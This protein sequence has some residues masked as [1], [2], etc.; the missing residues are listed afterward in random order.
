MGSLQLC[1][2]TATMRAVLILGLMLSA[3]LTADE[4]NQC[5]ER[6]QKSNL[7]VRSGHWTVWAHLNPSFQAWVSISEGRL[8]SYRFSEPFGNVSKENPQSFLY[9]NAVESCREFC[10]DFESEIKKQIGFQLVA[11]GLVGGLVIL[12]LRRFKRRR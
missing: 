9:S 10:E 5:V 7:R 4:L 8:E 2:E 11:T 3:V 6:L 1:I 12:S